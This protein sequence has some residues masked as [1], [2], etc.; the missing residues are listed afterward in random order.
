M[1]TVEKIV[2]KMHVM[3][4]IDDYSMFSQ[5]R[6]HFT[7]LINK[8]VCFPGRLAFRYTYRG[9]Y[10]CSQARARIVAPSEEMM[11]VL[12]RV[13]VSLHRVKR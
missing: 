6:A 7:T 11:C 4:S 1:A 3:T 2:F 9:D 12:R 8:M 13:R 10:V 5:A